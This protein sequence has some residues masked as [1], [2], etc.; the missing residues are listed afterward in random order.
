[1]N[2]KKTTIEFTGN[3]NH[4]EKTNKPLNN[5]LSFQGDT[6]IESYGFFVPSKYALS[7]KI[8]QSEN[9]DMQTLAAEKLYGIH[10]AFRGVE[11]LPPIIF[12][13]VKLNPDKKYAVNKAS[14]PILCA[15]NRVFNLNK[16]RLE[17]GR[18]YK[19]GR[20]RRGDIFADDS[21]VSFEHATIQYVNGYY[22]IQDLNSL[23]GTKICPSYKITNP[24]ELCR[25]KGN[26]GKP[27]SEIYIKNNEL[28][29]KEFFKG[30]VSGKSTQSP[31]G[32]I[33]TLNQAHKM[34]CKGWSLYYTKDNKLLSTED[35]QPGIQRNYEKPRNGRIESAYEVEKIAR[36]YGDKYSVNKDCQR[37]ELTGINRYAQ[38]CDVNINGIYS[39]FYPDGRYL[40]AYNYYLYITHREV[41]DLI[42]KLKYEDFDRRILLSKI[43]EHYQY[44]ANA[45]P[46][47]QINN[48]LFMN[49]V[50]T[51]LQLA[52]MP[53]MVQGK[54]LDHAAQRMQPKNFEKYFI[55][56]Y[57]ENQIN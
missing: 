19:L 35:L 6:T 22:I 18:I 11:I 27:V 38:P 24:D 10:N 3:K 13:E 33:E 55:D 14:N 15:A 4:V 16:L 41:I 8:Y 25:T 43:A 2:I 34:A 45:R 54:Y 46:Y 48:S 56:F 20:N 37:V 57:L 21:D 29:R 1:M 7:N 23:N 50:N 12:D 28:A 40:D 49:E 36:K 51:Y 32:Y 53:K 44:G 17:E 39:H 26:E 52:G 42:S 31:K 9:K 47:N 5:T 30:I